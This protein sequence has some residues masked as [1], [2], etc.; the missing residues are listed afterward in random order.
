MM[1]MMDMMEDKIIDST[2]WQYFDDGDD[3]DDGR[4]GDE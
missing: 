3:G 4:D 2:K 1:E